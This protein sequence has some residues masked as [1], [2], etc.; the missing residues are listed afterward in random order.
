MLNDFYMLELYFGPIESAQSFEKLVRKYGSKAVLENIKDGFLQ[1]T[2]RLS[3]AGRQEWFV[4]LS[5][6]GRAQIHDQAIQ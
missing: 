4:W 5:D 6:K 3:C 2:S 1:K